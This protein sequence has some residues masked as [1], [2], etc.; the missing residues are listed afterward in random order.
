ML[1]PL[2]RYAHIEFRSIAKTL[3]KNR[4][5]PGKLIYM[6]TLTLSTGLSLL[7]ENIQRVEFYPRGS[8]RVNALIYAISAGR[9]G[10][11]EVNEQD[12][13]CIHTTDGKIHVRGSGAAQDVTALEEA[14]IWV[15]RSPKN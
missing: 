14:G 12:F 1:P 7:S 8:F 11:L 13:L 6:Q 15:Y 9:N 10:A 4:T 3:P 5:I 2:F